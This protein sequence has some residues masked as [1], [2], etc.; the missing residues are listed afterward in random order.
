MGANTAVQTNKKTF[1]QWLRSRKGQQ[2]VIIVAF[3]I[4]PLLLLFTFTYLPF[5]EMVKFS[6]YKMKYVGARKFVGLD[7]YRALFARKDIVSSLKLCL[8]Y[9]A[10]ALIQIALALYL[11]TILS[12]KVKA[13]GLF[14]GLIFFPY[15]TMVLRLDL[16]LSF[17]TQG[18]LCSIQFCSGAVF[19]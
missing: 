1:G 8:Y 12:M 19:N 10:G 2:T 3:I 11:A 17:F 15:L 18:A 6:F 13:S 9:M 5:A 4:I 14:K 16:S 7:N